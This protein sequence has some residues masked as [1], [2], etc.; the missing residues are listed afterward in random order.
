MM[1]RIHKCILCFSMLMLLSS[2]SLLAQQEVIPFKAK[3]AVF[4][5]LAGNSMHYY[6]LNYERM[7]YQKGIFKSAARVG[8]TAF[9]R[10]IETEPKAFWDFALPLEVVG[11]IGRFR[12]HLELGVGFTPKYYAD[13]KF[14]IGSRG[15]EFDRYQFSSAIPFRIGY[16]YQ[17]PDGGLLFRAGLMPTRS[18]HPE[19][20]RKWILVYGGISLGMSF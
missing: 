3:N 10:K 13:S 19:L 9:P 15:Y 16:R 7:F 18:F 2:L 20:I 17:K 4:I 6:S 14:E 5:E 12:H 1:T 8:I 11:L